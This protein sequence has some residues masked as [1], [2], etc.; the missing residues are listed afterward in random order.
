[1]PLIVAFAITLYEALTRGA[2]HRLFYKFV[3][4]VLSFIALLVSCWIVWS[5]D[6]TARNFR[7]ADQRQWNRIEGKLGDEEATRRYLDAVGN[8]TRQ[9]TAAKAGGSVE[10]FFSSETER[11]RLRDEVNGANQKLLW[12]Y[13]IRMNPVRDYVISKFDGWISGIQNHGVK[14]QLSNRDVPAV[15]IGARADGDAR[16]AVYD[17]GDEIDLRLWSAL[18]KDGQFTEP[19]LCRM[20]WIPKDKS[21]QEVIFAMDVQEH[22]YSTRT[23]RPRFKYKPYTGKS[24]NP[25]EDK[26]FITSVDDAADEAMAFVVEEAT[27]K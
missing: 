1:M 17:S 13:E 15:A 8:L 11:H 12:A 2:K 21:G 23:T 4:P 27:S 24:D 10:K 7:N 20:L 5:D 25:I 18:I 16:K 9:L 26:E 14:V 3:L 22:D 19:F 6:K